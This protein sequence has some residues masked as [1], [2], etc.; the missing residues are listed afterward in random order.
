MILC[1]KIVFD[2]TY[3]CDCL[4]GGKKIKMIRQEH[5]DPRWMFPFVSYTTRLGDGKLPLIIQLHGAGERGHGGDELCMVD[6]IGFSKAIANDN[7]HECMVVMPQCPADS[8]WAARVESLIKFIEQLKDEFDIDADR[9]SLTGFSMGGFGTWFTAMACPELFSAIAPVCGGGMSWN[10]GVLNMPV[11]VFHGAADPVVPVVYSDP[12][13]DGMRNVGL[14]V[15]YSRIDGV[16]HN[17]WDMTY[18]IELFEWLLSHKK[19]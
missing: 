18:D 15:K 12:M 7:T 2:N 9:I 19:A 10:A 8:F 4:N 16:S 17:V 5:N 13:V 11:W 1:V 14:D 3:V 6:G